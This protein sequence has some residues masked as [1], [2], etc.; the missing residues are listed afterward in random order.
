MKEKEMN[1][2]QRGVNRYQ[3]QMIPSLTSG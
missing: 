1:C 3:W 2:K